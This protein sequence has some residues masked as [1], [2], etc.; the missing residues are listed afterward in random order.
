MGKTDLAQTL[1]SDR[2]VAV[3]SGPFELTASCVDVDGVAQLKMHVDGEVVLRAS[4]TDPLEA[5]VGGIRVQAGTDSARDGEVVLD[6]IV[7]RELG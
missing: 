3:P 7:V 1:A 4:D 6:R 5:G 2:S